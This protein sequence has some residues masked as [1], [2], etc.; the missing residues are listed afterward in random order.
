MRWML[1]T[2]TFPPEVNGVAMTLSK[3]V[4]GLIAHGH[5]VHIIRPSRGWHDKPV[6]APANPS[7]TLVWGIPFPWYEQIRLGLPYFGQL[8]HQIKKF[9]PDFLHI[10]TEGP[11]GLAGVLAAHAYKVPVVSSYHTNFFV[12]SRYYGLGFLRSIGFW[13]FRVLHNATLRTFVPSQ[14]S[15]Q[16]LQGYKYKNLEIMSR[17]VDTK[18]FTPAKRNEELRKTWGAGPHDTV[19]LYVG[20]VAGEKN[21][22]LTVKCYER[23]RQREPNARF[24]VV[25]DGPERKALQKNN[26]HF[27]FA[28]VKSGEEL[29]QY[30]ASADLFVFASFTETYGNVV[31]EALASGLV[32]LAYDYAAARENITDG[33]NGF[34]APFKKENLF[35]EHFNRVIDQ[36]NRWGNLAQAARATAEKLSWEN[37]VA[38]YE[39]TLLE[40]KCHAR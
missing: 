17:G 8:R 20:R 14:I 27:I 35:L 6:K 33:Q 37:V 31:T 12:Y 36:K 22:K 30:Y 39:K 4:D 1:I 25:G 10:S 23:L 19:M 3:L 40:L 13:Y 21:I 32:V 7:H 38:K 29:A 26:P 16:Q 9:K 28:G 34:T 5:E 11:L 15:L 24:V 2:E 18:R